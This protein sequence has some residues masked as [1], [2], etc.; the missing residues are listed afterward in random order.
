M[1]YTSTPP[2]QPGY[3]WLK[4]ATGEEIV[5][6]WEDPGHPTAGALFIH[7]CGSGDCAEVISLNQAQWAGPIPRPEPTN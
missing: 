2:T 5:E 1:K 7:H 4:D 6:I 3:Y